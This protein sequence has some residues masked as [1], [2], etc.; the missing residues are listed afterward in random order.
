MM[1]TLSFPIRSRHTEAKLDVYILDET[2]RIEMK[3]PIEGRPF[4]L[5]IPGGGYSMK[6]A[7]EAEPI[8]MR[9]LA[10]GFN[11]AVLWYSTAPA[12]FPSALEEMAQSMALIRSHKEEWNVGKVFA[13]GFSAG[14]HLTASLGV[15]WNDP[16]LSQATGLDPESY[17]P[18]G[19]VLSYPVITSGEK[20]HDGSFRNLL[21]ELYEDELAR[22]QVSLEKQVTEDAAPAF[23]WHTYTDQ[24]VPIENALLLATAYAEK[25]RPMELHV[26]PTGWHGLATVDY[27]TNTSPNTPFE[28][29]EWLPM[30]IRWAKSICEE[31]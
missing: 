19:V 4:M 26:F 27:E 2:H 14:G 15:L 28:A 11:A 10:A 5:V 9:Y 31:K 22:E 18:D 6:S 17:R 1:Q 23:I 21:G 25:K 30:S 24:V 7:R 3:T 29:G 20:R 8:A 16:L 13:V 12:T